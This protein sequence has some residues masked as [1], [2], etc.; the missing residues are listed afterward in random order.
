MDG[1]GAARRSRRV[2]LFR[3]VRVPHSVSVGVGRQCGHVEADQAKDRVVFFFFFF[4]DLITDLYID[5]IIQVQG[6]TVSGFPN[7]P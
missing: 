3:V 6:L 4:R 1:G 2:C 7:K 5:I